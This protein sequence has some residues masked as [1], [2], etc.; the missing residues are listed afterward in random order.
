MSLPLVSDLPNHISILLILG[1]LT[2]LL[3][4]SFT[5]FFISFTHLIR[6]EIQIKTIRQYLLFLS[7]LILFTLIYWEIDVHFIE[8]PHPG[9]PYIFFILIATIFFG[10]R[11]GL[12]TFGLTIFLVDYYLFEPRFTFYLIHHDVDMAMIIAGL[13]V[14]LFI[15]QRIRFYEETIRK[16]NEELG[17]L[18]KARERLLAVAA[19]ELR[20]PLTAISLCS[21]ILSKQY[22]QQEIGSTLQ[23]SIQTIK[24]ETVSLTE[25]I[26]DLL[27]FSR[28]QNNKS[29]LK[30]EYFDLRELITRKIETVQSLFPDHR[31]IFQQQLTSS[32]IYADR[33]SIERIIMNLLTN[34]G[35]YSE[36]D[37]KII[38]RLQKD[39]NNYVVN[40]EDHGVGINLEQQA[41]VFEPYYQV[42]NGKQGLGLGLY[43]TKTLVKMHNGKIWIE[44][45]I[46]KGSTFSVTL[47]K[48]V[49]KKY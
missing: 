38:I 12:I 18:I 35:K 25:M 28:V 11:I 23:R 47:P 9:I 34:A 5:K 22:K 14:S 6:T 21:Q 13:I 10:A 15:G 29:S 42:E 16:R 2:V 31:Y 24:R 20:T 1:I 49:S 39:M 27:D 48:R 17:F 7:L 43:I 19:H 37:T 3:L 32:K 4:L 36:Q 26:N 30:P 8:L 46:G 44:S 41:R 40:V 33:L 45:K